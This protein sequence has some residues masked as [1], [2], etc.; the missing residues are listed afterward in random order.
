MSSQVGIQRFLMNFLPPDK[1]PEGAINFLSGRIQVALSVLDNALADR[2][3]LVGN[4]ISVADLSCCGYL[5]YDEPFGFNR[6]EWPNIN[7]WLTRISDQPGWKH[8]YD[9]M[10]RAFTP[11]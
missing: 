5:F 4:S 7:T 6:S 10:K 1:R 3:W 11:S 8:P 9:L 2:D